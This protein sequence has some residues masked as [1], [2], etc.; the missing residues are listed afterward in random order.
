M[1]WLVLV[2]LG[3]CSGDDGGDDGLDDGGTAVD[4]PSGDCRAHGD[5]G[6]AGYHSPAGLAY[7]PDCM[8]PLQREYYRVFV[9]DD[10]LASMIPRPDGA[11]IGAG[12]CDGDDP[13]VMSLVERYPLCDE[14]LDAAGVER[15]NSMQPG[16]ALRVARLLHE[17]LIFTIPDGELTP[18]APP[19]DI[20]DAC[21]LSSDPSAQLTSL[22]EREADRLQSGNEIGFSYEGVGAAELARLLNRLYGIDGDARV[23]ALPFETGPCDAA[24]PVFSFDAAAGDCAAQSYGGCEGNANR[25][26]ERAQCEAFCGGG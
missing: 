17:R 16:D 14:T 9:D 3:A 10:G 13:E 19:T 4:N 7:L 22:C 1:G 23:C 11:F 21:A 2:A 5:G 6:R 18:F 25:F 24:F 26:V 20:L 15:I 12:L 8:N